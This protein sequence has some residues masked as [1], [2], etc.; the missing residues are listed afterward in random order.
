MAQALRVLSP[1][2]REVLTLVAEG[3]TNQEIADQLVISIKTVQAHR[4]HVMKE[5]GLVHITQLV[6]FAIRHGL[7]PPGF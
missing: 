2:E 6:R 1:R 7:V 3:H 5:L 4:A